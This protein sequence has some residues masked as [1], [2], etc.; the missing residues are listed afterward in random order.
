MEVSGSANSLKKGKKGRGRR[1]E[2]ERE[3]KRSRFFLDTLQLDTLGDFVLF[4]LLFI[5]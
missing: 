4:W 1:E 5:R 3:K 2:R